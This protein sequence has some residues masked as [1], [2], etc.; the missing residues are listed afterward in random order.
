MRRIRLRN[1]KVPAAPLCV[2]RRRA[3]GSSSDNGDHD[4]TVT[5]K[6]GTQPDLSITVWCS[7]NAHV[8]EI[9]QRTPAHT[10]S[11]G[12]VQQRMVK[13]QNVLLFGGCWRVATLTVKSCPPWSLLLS[14][15]SFAYNGDFSTAGHTAPD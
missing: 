14:A 1:R 12:A 9:L 3:Y 15:R 11:I 2:S 7:R 6:Q 13:N 4:N 10:R 8:S 5:T